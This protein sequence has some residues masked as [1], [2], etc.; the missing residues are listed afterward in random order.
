MYLHMIANVNLYKTL[1]FRNKL[2]PT[3]LIKQHEFQFT[4]VF[5]KQALVFTC[6]QYKFFE[7]TV[8]KGEIAHYK[9][10]LLFS[11]CFLPIWRIVCHF[12][13]T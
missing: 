2:L 5:P 8:G 1:F 9:Q 11:P 12:Q 7:N 10:F 3:I 13:K 6:L 4:Q